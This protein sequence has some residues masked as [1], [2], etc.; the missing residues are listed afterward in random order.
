MPVQG[1]KMKNRPQHLLQY[2]VLYAECL[3]IDHCT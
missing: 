2:V 3:K 1:N